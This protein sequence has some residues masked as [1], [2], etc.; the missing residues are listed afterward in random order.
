MKIQ[1]AITRARKDL[2]ISSDDSTVGKRYIYAGMK[3]VRKEMLRQEVEKKGSWLNMPMQ[4]LKRFTLEQVDITE[5]LIYT[6]GEMLLKSTLPFPTLLDTKDGKIMGGVF[7]LN[8]E[9]LELTSYTG[10]INTKNRRYQSLLPKVFF[11]D[12]HVYV[13]YYNTDTVKLF[14]NIDGMFED[15]EEVTHLN[16]VDDCNGNSD[17]CIFYPD[18]DFELPGYLEGRFFRFLRADLAQSLGIPKDKINNGNE[19][20]TLSSGQLPRQQTET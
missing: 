3:S 5:S 1:E 15:P 10:S 9:R 14:V 20:V 11:R 4:T 18:V 16:F 7:L 13:R 12:K 17:T 8:G 2:G 6:T 19:D